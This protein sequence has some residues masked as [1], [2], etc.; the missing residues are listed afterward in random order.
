MKRIVKASS[1]IP[2][3][4][5]MIFMLLSNHIFFIKAVPCS[6]CTSAAVVLTFQ[7]CKK[8]EE[9]DQISNEGVKR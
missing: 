3:M 8:R 1:M 5:G 6:A 9:P 7:A 4:M 2:G